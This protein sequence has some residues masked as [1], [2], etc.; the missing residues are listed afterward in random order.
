MICPTI[1]QVE[2]PLPHHKSWHMNPIC[3]TY[4]GQVTFPKG[5][6]TKKELAHVRISAKANQFHRLYRCAHFMKRFRVSYIAALKLY[7]T[8]ERRANNL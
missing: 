2:S 1:E 3:E 5:S 6:L 8:E 7:F 4:I